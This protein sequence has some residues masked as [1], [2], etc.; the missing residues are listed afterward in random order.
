MTIPSSTVIR[1]THNKGQP[2]AAVPL[3]GGTLP[4][5]V[6]NP[7]KKEVSTRTVNEQFYLSELPF[8]L[9]YIFEKLNTDLIFQIPPA[10]IEIEVTRSTAA[11]TR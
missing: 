3:G 2:S 7:Q 11:R 8:A 9:I 6:A 10:A 1:K 5:L 4:M